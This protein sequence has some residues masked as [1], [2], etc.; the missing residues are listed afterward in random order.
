MQES[1]TGNQRPP[2]RTTATLDSE[3]EEE[4]DDEPDFRYLQALA[5]VRSRQYAAAAKMLAAPAEEGYAAA[6]YLL[7]DMYMDG[8]GLERDVC[9]AFTLYRSAAD[10]DHEDGLLMAS[11]CYIQGL[12]TNRSWEMGLTLAARAASLHGNP[13]AQMVL[14]RSYEHGNGVGVDL[15]RALYYYCE[16]AE[17]G[18]SEAMFCLAKFYERG[19]GNSTPDLSLA[20]EWYKRAAKVS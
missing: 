9:K 12:G 15:M 17:Q 3:D 14:G 11:Y 4:E 1:F 19:K 20:L 16:A 6:S 2:A 10:Q 8:L 13:S 18:E 5:L 7:G